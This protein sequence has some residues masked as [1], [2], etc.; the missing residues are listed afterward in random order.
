MT[1]FKIYFVHYEYLPTKDERGF[2]IFAMDESDA[3]RL[4]DILFKNAY[5]F[6][7]SDYEIHEIKHDP[8]QIALKNNDLISIDML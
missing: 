7:K 6:E 4:S 1:N 3:R 8:E 5:D 2:W